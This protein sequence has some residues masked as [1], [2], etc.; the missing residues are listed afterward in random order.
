MDQ[1][2]AR[3]A[4]FFTILIVMVIWEF[5]SPRRKRPVSRKQR[6]PSNLSIIII[7]TFTLR[8]IFPT[9]AIGAAVLAEKNGWGLFNLL[10][11]WPAM[12]IIASVLLLDLAIYIQHVA[13]HKV[14]LLWNFHRMHHSDIDLDITSGLRFHPVEIVFSMT[15][16]YLVIFLLGAPIMA[17][18]LF[19]VILNGSAMFNHS[20][21]NIPEKMDRWLRL[22]IVTPDMHR[23]HHSIV[24]AETDS[25]YGFNV[26]WWDRLFGTYK[27][28]PTPNQHD[29]TI[30]LPIFREPEQQT[31][32]GLLKQPFQQQK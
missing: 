3:L 5:I 14:P 26:P 6:W 32:I 30:G 21:V 2:I 4:P 24:R 11:L 17:V 23:V 29:M 20:N 8:L 25:N 1:P 16:K 13:V 18:F 7:N 10:D 9:A 19:E 22:L 31:L 12:A 15:I 27:A 28:T